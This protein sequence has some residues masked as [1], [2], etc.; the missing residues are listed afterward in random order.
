MQNMNNKNTKIT[1]HDHLVVFFYPHQKTGR[2]LKFLS[3]FQSCHF[4]QTF[5]YD[6]I[7]FK[8]E[9]EK[10]ITYFFSHSVFYV[11]VCI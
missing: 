4:T 10:R 2:V 1:K 7:V 5:F 6:K 9:H 11:I 3:L 8:R